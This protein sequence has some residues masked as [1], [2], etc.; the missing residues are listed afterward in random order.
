MSEENVETVRRGYELYAA[1]D[2]QGVAALFSQDAE[3]ADGGG[4][5]VAGT[6]PCCDAQTTTP[7]ARSGIARAADGASCVGPFLLVEDIVDK[8]RPPPAR[9]S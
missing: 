2:L 4:L 9:A 3:L 8:P 7:T 1:G 5:G 6:G